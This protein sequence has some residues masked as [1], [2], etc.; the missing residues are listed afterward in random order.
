[1]EQIPCND[2]YIRPGSNHS[3]DGGTKGLGDVGFPLI[4][5]G[6]GLP[7]VLPDAKVGVCNVGQFHGWRMDL[8][9][10][11]SKHLNAV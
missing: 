4:D 8:N 10:L 6:R 7:V 1:M 9:T 5:T 3:V 2:D 11:N